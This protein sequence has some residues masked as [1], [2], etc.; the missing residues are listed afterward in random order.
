MKAR[1]VA[2]VAMLAV[3]L[4]SAGV[5]PALAQETDANS[6]A[7]PTAA[8][9]ERQTATPTEAQTATPTPTTP[10]PEDVRVRNGPYDIVELRAMGQREGRDASPSVRGIG[11]P[12]RGFAAARYRDPSLIDAVQGNPGPW[13]EVAAGDTIEQNRIQIY[14]SAFGDVAGEYELVIVYWNEETTQVDNHSVAYAANQ[15]VQRE[16]V[17]FAKEDLYSYHNVSLPSHTEQTVK[18]TM[19]LE[20]DDE[21]VDGAQWSGIKHR[22]NPESESVSIDSAA[23][24]WGFALRNAVLPGIASLIAGLVSARAVLRQTGRGPGYGLGSWLFITGLV[25]FFVAAIAYYQI[26]VIL[27]NLPWVM[28]VSIGVIAFA[29]GL[30]FHQPVKKIGFERR[31][32]RDAVTIPGGSPAS[33]ATDG[34]VAQGGVFGGDDGGAEMFDEFT[35]ALYRDLPE[36]PAVRTDDGY[37]VPVLGLRPFFARIFA[38]AALLDV[39][40]I[41]TRQKVGVGRLSDIIVV[42]P[43]SETAVEHKPARLVRVLPW[44]TLDENASWVEELV[45]GLLTAVILFAPASTGWIAF[46]RLMNIPTVGM[47]LGILVTIII[48]YSAEDGWIEF[49]PAPPHYHRAEDTLTGLQRAYKESK[50]DKSSKEEAWEERAKTAREG[51]EDRAAEQRTVTDKILGGLGVDDTVE[52]PEKRD[53]HSPDEQP[54]GDAEGDGA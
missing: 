5:A 47:F 3:L 38:N 22:S 19:W 30:T 15:T 49:E 46:E 28:G 42:D 53:Y 24:A 16:K 4:V 34:G 40:N 14:G 29:A 6:T 21:K 37:R 43:D 18:M 10:G 13:K 26:A 36:I 12:P 50:E 51:R 1:S 2:F 52:E 27:S 23:G 33:K 32:L 11:D 8:Q 31:E 25:G 39:S 7:P 20:R 44:D 17:T 48:S 35:E 45:A 54:D 41:A 9:N